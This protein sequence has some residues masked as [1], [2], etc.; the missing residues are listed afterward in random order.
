M[1]PRSDLESPTPVF[2]SG[3]SPAPDSRRR[4]RRAARLPLLRPITNLPGF[5]RGKQSTG[6]HSTNGTGHSA[7]PGSAGGKSCAELPAECEAAGPSCE[8]RERAKEAASG[9]PHGTPAAGEASWGR[10]GPREESSWELPGAAEESAEPR[11]P[12]L[13]A[14]F[15]GWEDSGREEVGRVSHAPAKAACE[16]SPARSPADSKG[17]WTRVRRPE[18]SSDCCYGGLCNH[19]R[20]WGMSS[21]RES[22]R[23]WERAVPA[24]VNTDSGGVGGSPT[25]RKDCGIDGPRSDLPERRPSIRPLPSGPSDYGHPTNDGHPRWKS[26]RRPRGSTSRRGSRH[27][28]RPIPT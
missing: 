21:G 26:R 5:R 1:S 27:I 28:G 3:S 20:D 12:P 25:Q 23:H 16:A 2:G 4:H 6:D 22:A 15:W 10:R 13:E 11:G 18:G 8:S 24:A 17:G 14:A 19:V 7:A 9:E